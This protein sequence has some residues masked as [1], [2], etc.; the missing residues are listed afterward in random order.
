M[1][2]TSKIYSQHAMLTRK[3]LANSIRALAIDAVSRANSGH[4]G[5][6]M[7][8]ADIAEVLWRDFLH[9]NPANPQWINRDRFILSNG[10]GCLLQYALLHLTGYALSIEDLKQFRQFESKTPGHPEFGV[11]PGVEATT[12]P[13][14]QGLA[15]AV[16]MAI[17][18]KHLS[19][20]FN[21]ESFDIVN[22]FTYVFVGDGCLM[23]GIS[24]EAAS[25][26]GTLRLGKL[27]VF[28]DDNGI[29]IDGR[30]STW[31]TDDTPKRFEAYHW[32]VIANVDG[33]HSGAIQK[34]IETA[35]ND[36]SRPTLICCKTQIGYGAPNLAGSEKTHGA[37]LGD[38]ESSLAKKALA[39][40]YPPFEI[41]K[42]YYDAW[43]AKQKGAQLESSWQQLFS[44][45]EKQFPEEAQELLRRTQ[46]KLPI[47]FKQ[48]STVYIAQLKSET[49]PT[50]TRKSSQQCIEAFL[51]IVP[52]L[53]GGSAD[54]SESNGLKLKNAPLLTKENARGI[55]LHYGVREFAMSAIMNG[56]ALHRGIIPFGGTFLTFLDYARSAVRM[57]AIM[58]AK[59]IYVYSHDSVG[60]GEDGPTHQPIEHI[61]MLR[62]TPHLEIWRPCDAVETA[63]AW[64]QMLLHAGPS[65]I[66]LTRQ[67]V[68]Q[69]PHADPTEKIIEN[70]SRGAEIIFEPQKKIEAIIIA[71]G[72]EV[73]LA[74]D[75]AKQ[76]SSDNIQVRVVSMLCCE[77]FKKQDAA[78]QEKILPSHIRAR[79]AIEA[80]APDYWRQFVGDAGKILGIERFGASAPQEAI[81]KAFGFTVEN[82]KQQILENRTRA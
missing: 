32:Q 1:I 42:E 43:N 12:G 54:L 27:I 44:Q 48:K 8:M 11:T 80:G 68:P 78:F 75:A 29:S 37:P 31:F 70:I 50:A 16:G 82:I 72:S 23:E 36:L 2:R 58:Q 76:L 41:P 26:A 21:R 73:A 62:M 4:P 35:Q 55:F 22:H 38:T 63:V 28:Y 30:V 64:Q 79:L 19:A 65:V 10:H 9:H 52:E 49:K 53:L 34:A 74:V 39:W 6:P 17:A 25:L 13:L 3:Q 24:H 77:R 33:H 69:Q 7:G 15:M 45:Y 66:L 56:M 40:D 14:G 81:W 46:L 18:E 57:S 67:N 61:A 60:L 59:V 47:D 71:T 51:E 5:M 20:E